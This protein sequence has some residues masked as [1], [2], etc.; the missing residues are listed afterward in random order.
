MTPISMMI[1]ILLEPL[2]K[3]LNL[4]RISLS[5]CHH[6]WPRLRPRRL[7]M[8]KRRDIPKTDPS[9]I[10]ALIRRLKQSNL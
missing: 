9:E 4:G 7:M 5:E 6:A 1:S 2:D 8:A 10:E 3:R